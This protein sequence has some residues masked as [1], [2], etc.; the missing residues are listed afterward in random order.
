MACCKIDLASYFGESRGIFWTEIFYDG[1][2][3]GTQ[4]ERRSTRHSTQSD[5][6]QNERLNDDEQYGRE[7][8]DA[9]S[10]HNLHH[11]DTSTPVFILFV[12]LSCIAKVYWLYVECIHGLFFTCNNRSLYLMYVIP[13]LSRMTI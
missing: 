5:K 9:F 10:T 11:C 8:I 6:K 2:R 3:M 1:M 12:Y 13:R 4:D 7:Q